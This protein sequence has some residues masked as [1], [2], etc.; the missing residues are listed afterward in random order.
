[1]NVTNA[2]PEEIVNEDDNQQT[3]LTRWL[4]L[5]LIVLSAGLGLVAGRVI[6]NFLIIKVMKK[7]KNNEDN[8]EKYTKN[9]LS[10]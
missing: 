2:K 4:W 6:L 10:V 1:L 8:E 5:T 7:T 3:A 9:I